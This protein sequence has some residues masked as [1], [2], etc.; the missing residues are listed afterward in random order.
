MFKLEQETYNS[1][2]V[3]WQVTPSRRGVVSRVT[4]VCA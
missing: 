2:G 4:C 3:E 1:E